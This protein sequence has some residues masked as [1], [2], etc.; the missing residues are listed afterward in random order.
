MSQYGELIG[1][2]SPETGR[3][4][5]EFASYFGYPTLKKVRNDDKGYSVYMTKTYCLLSTECRY[6]IAI[7][8]QDN[9]PVGSTEKL[10]E[11][12]W[13]SLQTRTL[14]IMP[15]IPSHS[16]TPVRG[17]FLL[18]KIHRTSTNEV[19]STYECTELPVTITLLKSKQNTSIEY[20]PSG[21]IQAAIETYQTII[22]LNQN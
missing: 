22:T 9:F 19:S 10:T 7:V 15:N 20:Q 12:P 14:P 13:V 18:K 6:I 17:G 5:E 16:Y 1:V 21:D 8:P 2:Y 3:I 4:Y 11:L